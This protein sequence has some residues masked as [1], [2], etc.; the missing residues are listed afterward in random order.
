MAKD[1]NIPTVKTDRRKLDE[2]S[3]TKSH[4]GV[5]AYVA[6][7]EYV[8]LKEIVSIAKQKGE[9]PFVIISMIFILFPFPYAL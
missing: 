3:E 1:K 8:S 2:I 5:I 6:A 4:Q 7:K 9:K